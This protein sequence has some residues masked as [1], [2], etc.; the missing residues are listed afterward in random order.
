ML[1][2]AWPSPGLF[3]NGRKAEIFQESERILKETLAASV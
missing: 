3:F 1:L 2:I